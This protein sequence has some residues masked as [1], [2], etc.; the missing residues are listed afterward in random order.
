MVLVAMKKIFKV[1]FSSA[2]VFALTAQLLLI[3]NAAETKLVAITFDDGPSKYT[4]ELLDGLKKLKAKATFFMVG[5]NV[6]AYPDTV[7]RM[8]DEGH[9]LATHTMS[10]ANL[11]KLSPDKI[12][13]EVEEVDRRIDK[14]TGGGKYYLRPPYGAFNSTVKSTVKTP[15]IHWS[16]DTEDWRY[17][18]AD[19]VYNVIVNHIHDGD[20]ILLHDLYETSVKGALHAIEDLQKQGYVFV[21][22]EQLFRRRGIEPEDGKVYFDA[23]NLGINL[24]AVVSPVIVGRETVLGTKVVIGKY[25]F[26]DKIYYTDDKKEPDEECPQYVGSFYVDRDTM[27]RAIAVG[28]TELSDIAEK[29]LVLPEAPDKAIMDHARFKNR[30]PFLRQEKRFV[31]GMKI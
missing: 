30:S 11:P 19:S 13:Y 21:T 7:R 31:I 10:H 1:I 17:R 26:I 25:A 16:L 8:K 23:P 24:P 28:E 29:Q 3:C 9:Q 22:V 18:N 14:V 20:I 6:S 27:L 12:L 4:N 2:L 15:M 5:S